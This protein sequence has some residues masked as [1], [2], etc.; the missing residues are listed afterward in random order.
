[1]NQENPIRQYH[2]GLAPGDVARR[3]LF[4][5]DPTRVRRFS[6]NLDEIRGEWTCREYL[7]ITGTWKGQE[8]SLMATGIGASN[9]EIAMVELS[10]IVEDPILIRAGSCGGIDSEIHLGDLVVS[11]GAVRMENTST[12][13]VP[14]GYPAV[15]HPDVVQALMASSRQIGAPVHMGITATA[16]GF[17]GAQGR[18]EPGFP[19][20]D[21]QVI[22]RLA[23]IGV[24]N[25]EMEASTLF[26]LASM[27]KWRAG[28][29]CTVFG[30]RQHDEFLNPE[31]KPALEDRC[32]NVALDALVNLEL[33]Q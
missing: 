15:A 1:M 17:Y 30:R 33:D 20:R 5:G 13:F 32:V 24:A 21:P 23:D 31:D 3:I 9:I 18:N 28:C 6:E 11:M 26:T 16:P 29:I 4:A 10:K 2:I 7:T 25:M 27:Q 12:T 22:D 14:E 8:V 19:P